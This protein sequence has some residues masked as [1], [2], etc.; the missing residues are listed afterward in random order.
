MSYQPYNGA[1]A[2]TKDILFENI[3]DKNGNKRFISIE[4]GGQYTGLE[5][6]YN[7][8]TLSGSHLMLVTVFYVPETTTVPAYTSFSNYVVPKWVGNLIYTL[9]SS[10]NCVSSG[11]FQ[12]MSV[13][14]DKMYDPIF[15]KLSK[16]NAGSAGDRLSIATP[17][18]PITLNGL[19]YYRLQFDLVIGE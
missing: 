9:D 5:Y 12:G 10:S 1:V 7:Q 13:W 6:K 18:T 16:D 17:S 15:V 19:T 2:H 8:A 3:V 11:S 14:A 4:G